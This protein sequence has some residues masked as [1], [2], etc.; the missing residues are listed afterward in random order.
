MTTTTLDKALCEYG[1]IYPTVFLK[2]DVQ[3]AEIEIL[4]GSRDTLAKVEVIQLEVALL[5]Y[6]DGA[7]LAADVLS[8]MN[9]RN[10]KL[11][12]IAGF[13]RVNG[14]DLVQMDMIFARA[15]STLRPDFFR[16]T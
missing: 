4:R 14:R 9:E 15:D 2:L 7:P 10:F 13:V 5:P 11:Y 6:N 8:F 1:P 12:D 16:F 3:G